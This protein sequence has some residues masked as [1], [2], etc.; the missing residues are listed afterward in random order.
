MNVIASVPV[1]LE[2]D[3]LD[4]VAILIALGTFLATV[5]GLYFV[6]QSL[7]QTVGQQR[8]ASGPYVRVDVGAFGVDMDDFK[9]PNVYYHSTDQILALEADRES[10]DSEDFIFTAW[11]RNYQEHRLG[12][13]LGVAA[14]FLLETREREPVLRE[15]HIAYLE[16]EKPV[17]VDLFSLPGSWSAKL[18]V[19]SVS[20]LDFYDHQH[21]HSLGTLGTNGLHGRLVCTL[22]GGLVR[23]IPEARSRKDGLPSFR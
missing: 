20:Y 10:T 15:V 5:I 12:M 16:L 3:L 23:T 6:A 14:T 8:T 17:A 19:L 11:F 21:E 1:D 9:P 13:A 7:N 4:Y 22:E 2:R 18:S